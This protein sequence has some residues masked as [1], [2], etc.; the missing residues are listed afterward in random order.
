MMKEVQEKKRKTIG[1]VLEKEKNYG[2]NECC[3]KVVCKFALLQCVRYDL[4][5]G[6]HRRHP[7]H[8]RRRHRHRHLATVPDQIVQFLFEN[9]FVRVSVFVCLLS[10][11]DCVSA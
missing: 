4:C 2:Q 9:E 7:K 3:A 5:C 1:F 6:C 10:W 11:C 8:H